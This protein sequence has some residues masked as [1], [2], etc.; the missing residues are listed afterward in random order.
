M[1]LRYKTMQ[2]LMKQYS[3]AEILMMVTR[4]LDDREARSDYHK[5]YNARKNALVKAINADPEL[6]RRAEELVNGR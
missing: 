3:E 4:Y 6:K 1:S 2:D 5:K